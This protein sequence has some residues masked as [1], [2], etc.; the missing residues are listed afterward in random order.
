MPNGREKIDAQC[1]KLSA[2]M[3]SGCFR[4]PHHQRRYEWE[5][6]HVSELLEDLEEARAEK[7][8]EYFLGTIMLIP[9]GVKNKG[10]GVVRAPIGT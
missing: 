4:V 1:V 6:K 3:S 9:Q 10:G 7:V 8:G 2:L 5:G